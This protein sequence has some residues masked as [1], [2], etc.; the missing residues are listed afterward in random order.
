M[1]SDAAFRDPLPGRWALGLRIAVVG[2]TTIILLSAV[3]L[4]GLRQLGEQVQEE[5]QHQAHMMVQLVINQITHIHALEVIGAIS[6]EQAKRQALESIEATRFVDGSYLWVHDLQG[7]ILAHP[8]QP[9]LVMASRKGELPENIKTLF[10]DFNRQVLVNGTAVISYSW[11][12]PGQSEPIRKLSYLQLM[13]PWGWVIGS[14]V[15]VDD[16]EAA[17]WQR[18]GVILVFCLLVGTISILILVH[19]FFGITSP[20]RQ[21]HTALSALAKGTIP[22]DPTDAPD[23]SGSSSANTAIKLIADRMR[24][25]R[26][27]QADSD[28]ELLKMAMALDTVREGVIITDDK[29]CILK[30]N[31][32]FTQLTG[33]SAEDAIGQTPNILSS[34]RHDRGFYET[35]WA[36]LRDKGYWSGEI[37]NRGKSGRIYPEVLTI[38]AISDVHGA[39]LGYVGAFSDVTEGK[40]QAEKIQWYADHDVLT[41]LI[42]RRTLEQQGPLTLRSA[43]S[44]AQLAAVLLIDVDD[45]KVTND[46][47]GHVAGDRILQAMARRLKESLGGDVIISRMGGDEFVCIIAP[48]ESRQSAHATA[49]RLLGELSLPVFIDGISIVHTVS[50]GLVIAPDHATLLDEAIRIADIALAKAKAEGRGRYVE[51]S[52]LP[53]NNS[54]YMI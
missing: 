10:A 23:W 40:R 20:L 12:R 2:L 4:Y 38:N 49:K 3:A 34:G 36:T 18:G 5:R 24:A 54:D 19:L 11:P 46:T 25:M 50:I 7:N 37:W 27:R 6:P 16:I 42:N 32:A 13:T 29:A 52:S 1:K 51:V 30:V 28:E 33:Y 14:G 35:L 39:L 9:E 21:M 15:Y 44:S 45:F 41:G 8:T 47:H 48:L 22:A 53:L 31:R 43:L 17:Q 26:R